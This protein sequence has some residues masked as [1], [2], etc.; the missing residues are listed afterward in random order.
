MSNLEKLETMTTKPSLTSIFEQIT[1]AILKDFSKIL[2]ISGICYLFGFIIVRSHLL[3]YGITEIDLLETKYIS[4]GLFFLIN[5]ALI[6]LPFIFIKLE[7]NSSKPLKN[8]FYQ[9]KSKIIYTIIAI[10]SFLFIVLFFLEKITVAIALLC[11]LIFIFSLLHLVYFEFSN[12]EQTSSSSSTNNIRLPTVEEVLETLLYFAQITIGIAI[13]HVFLYLSLEDNFYQSFFSFFSFDSHFILGYYK[14]LF[15][16]NLIWYFPLIII[17]FA[18]FILIS[19]DEEF[20]EYKENF[21]FLVKAKYWLIGT[22]TIVS[23]FTIQSYSYFIYPK[24]TVN[25]GGGNYTIVQLILAKDDSIIDPKHLTEIGIFQNNYDKSISSTNVCLIAQTSNYYYILPSTTNCTDMNTKFH[26][27][28]DSQ[29]IQ[30]NKSDVL[31][32]VYN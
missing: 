13:A 30:I 21:W 5:I 12:K 15:L 11:S 19:D 23:L 10:V 8:E 26:N 3:N 20:K 25:L 2:T 29:T 17:G 6:W 9:H 32:V 14:T 18:I 22:I 16:F 28:H 31:T 7:Y 24:V 27:L 1:N 4:V